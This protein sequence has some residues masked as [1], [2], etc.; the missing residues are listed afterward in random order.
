MTTDSSR[1][2]LT[3]CES[4]LVLC[5]CFGL[6][7]GFS[8]RI[9]GFVG[10]T[11]GTGV[12]L[13]V[14]EVRRCSGFGAGSRGACELDCGWPLFILSKRA[15]KDETAFCKSISST[16]QSVTFGVLTMDEPSVL[17]AGVSMVSYSNSP[18]PWVTGSTFPSRSV[19]VESFRGHQEL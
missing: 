14:L 17:S 12:S 19:V 5:R 7:G 11:G 1:A 4:R 6:T 10:V 18:L 9:G 16:M 3:C 2:G 15:S 13:V 8:F